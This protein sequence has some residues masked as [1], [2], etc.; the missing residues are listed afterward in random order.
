MCSAA[1]I[2]VGLGLGFR[3]GFG[4]GLGLVEGFE[5]VLGL[6]LGSGLGLGLRLG[7]GS[8]LVFQS[9]GWGRPHL[10]CGGAP[11]ELVTA[12]SED[13]LIRQTRSAALPL[14]AGRRGRWGR[15]SCG[16][17][18]GVFAKGLVGRGRVAGR[19]VLWGEQRLEQLGA[20]LCK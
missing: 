12:E 18:G 1:L 11:L 3:V 7:P 9:Q 13:L 17:G 20:R 16:G 10:C 4:L 14:P 5:P 19:G 6:G 2:W 8:G 15:C